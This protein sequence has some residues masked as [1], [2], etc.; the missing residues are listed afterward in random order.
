M[1]TRLLCTLLCSEC[2]RL[3]VSESLSCVWV[4]LRLHLRLFGCLSLLCLCALPPYPLSSFH[5]CLSRSLCLS[6]V[7][8]FF[9][10]AVC[11]CLSLPL[12]RSLLVSGFALSPPGQ[13]SGAGLEASLP[14]GAKLCHPLD[15][16]LRWEILEERPI[17]P[18]AIEG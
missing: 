15:S 16:P 4:S 5:L 17:T 18:Q 11:R 8:W 10:P 3:P 14:S 12:F 7:L 2:L 9:P 6:V 13:Q 1:W